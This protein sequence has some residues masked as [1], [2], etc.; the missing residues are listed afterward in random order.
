MER[1]TTMT[2]DERQQWFLDRLG[3][4]VFRNHNSCD[5]GVCGKVGDMGI[6]INNKLHAYYLQ[7]CELELEVMYFDTKEEALDYENCILTNG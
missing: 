4:R 7:D 5:C 3:K 2:Y 1:N 6:I